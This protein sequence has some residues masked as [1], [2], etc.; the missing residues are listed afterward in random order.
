MD[1]KARSKQMNHIVQRLLRCACHELLLP[2]QPL[3]RP[4]SA[5]GRPVL[6]SRPPHSP[7]TPSLADL[8]TMRPIC[9]LLP[10]L[11]LPLSPPQL[12]RV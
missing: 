8:L 6:T 1:K 7:E 2:L 3:L 11:P 12:R 4:S 10:R 9:P 5:A